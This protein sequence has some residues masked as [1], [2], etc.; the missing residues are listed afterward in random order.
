MSKGIY[1]LQEIYRELWGVSG[2]YTN[3]EF[4]KLINGLNTEAFDKSE[5]DKTSSIVP[6]SKH[7]KISTQQNTSLLLG[8][9][10]IFPLTLNDFKLSIEPIIQID[11]G[12]R[13][14]E[15]P[16]TGNDG[17]VIE[18]VSRIGYQIS[19]RGVLIGNGDEYPEEELRKLRTVLESKEAINVTCKLL[20][21]FNI[22]KIA[23]RRVK[24]HGNE[25]TESMQ[26]YEIEAVQDKDWEL[27]IREDSLNN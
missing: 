13:L 26:P 7:S 9:P 24:Y 21:Y 3:V 20:S 22:N 23:I 27:I 1:N 17:E 14:I 2:N 6:G 19:I 12:N 16:M 25:A 8:T 10:A 11:G 18:M 5:I 15:T 4:G